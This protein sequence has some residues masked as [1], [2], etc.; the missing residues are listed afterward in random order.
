MVFVA[1]MG[2]IVFLL[3]FFVRI[4]YPWLRDLDGQTDPEQLLPS[5]LGGFLILILCSVAF[6][7]YLHY[8]GFISLSFYIVIKVVIVCLVPTVALGI[9]DRIKSLKHQNDSLIIE[10]KIIQKQIERYEEENLNK[11]VE[12]SSDN[13]SD[14]LNLLIADLLLIKSADNYVEIVYVEGNEIKK[15]LLRNTLKNVELQIKQYTNFVRCHRICI[16]NTHF[17]EKMVSS[18]HNYALIIRGYNEQIPVSRQYLI[19]IRENI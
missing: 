6:C 10:K 2:G 16:V 1:G 14:N 19:K 11:T 4:V 15:K 18:Y 9:N 17:I 7:F 3:M 5:Y 12:I 8:V 13:K